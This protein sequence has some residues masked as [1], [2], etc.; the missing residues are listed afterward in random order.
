MFAICYHED[1]FT[2]NKRTN[3][4]PMCGLFLT[5]TRNLFLS[6]SHTN[7]CYLIY[8][9][10]FGIK[11]RKNPHLE[12]ESLVHGRESPSLLVSCLKPTAHCA[13]VISIL[14]APHSRH[15][16]IYLHTYRW[17]YHALFFFIGHITYKLIFLS[18]RWNTFLSDK[19]SLKRL[20]S[21]AFVAS[22][23][24]EQLCPWRAS[25]SP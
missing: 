19:T 13:P 16:Y 8:R 24:M 23:L 3:W 9:H 22:V 18:W 11:E 2:K 4:I 1:Q 12:K 15:H 25:T 7:T 20:G 21:H 6:N 17:H 5:C 14:P 10:V